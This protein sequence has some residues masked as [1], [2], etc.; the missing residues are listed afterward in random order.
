MQQMD[1][2]CA[3]RRMPTRPARRTHGRPAARVP[4]P[5][6][7][8]VFAL[9]VAWG[10]SA[11]TA[12]G[13]HP[14]AAGAD[15]APALPAAAHDA[16]FVLLGELHDNVG[17]HRLRLRWLEELADARRYVLALEQF[18]ADRQEALDRARAADAR[19]AKQS[20][21]AELAS[22]A[23]RIADAANFDF[24]GWDWDL[25]R[26]V[27]E[28]ALRRGLPLVAANLSPADTTKV[29]QGRAAP[30]PP[31]PGWGEDEA[32][33]MRMSIRDGHC[34]LLPEGVV[35]AMAVA[36]RTRDARIA[37][38]L[39]EAHEDTGLP[40]VLLAGNGH[41]RRDIGVPLHLAALRP[42]DRIVTIALLEP[43]LADERPEEGSASGSDRSAP[44]DFAIPTAAQPREDPCA[45]LRERMQRGERRTDRG[46]AAR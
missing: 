4:G 22:R 20:Q 28:L 10:A 29:T 11:C 6:L 38:A 26:P 16:E 24:D 7:R 33:K 23:R 40:V 2:A 25:Y 17:Q 32:E 43:Q 30:A 35:E 15:P 9:V 18:D 37:R 42:D 34:G 14:D 39:A 5:C 19:E 1:G 31:P 41:L 12:P 3:A 44:F 13:A 21:A 46:D 8:L 45:G 27:I 36:Q